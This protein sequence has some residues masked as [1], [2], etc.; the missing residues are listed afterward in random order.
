MKSIFFGAVS[1]VAMSLTTNARV[2][3]EPPGTLAAAILTWDGEYGT[4]LAGKPTNPRS[5]AIY[6]V[7]ENGG[8]HRPLVS[9]GGVTTYPRYSPAGDWLY[10]QS[11]SG[12]A[13]YQVYRCRANGSEVTSISAL[14]KLGDEWNHAFGN[15]LSGDGKKAVYSVTGG[16]PT[17]RVITCNADGSGRNGLGLIWDI[18]TWRRWT[19]PGKTWRSPVRH[20][21]TG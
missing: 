20:K 17:P 4:D 18:S 6:E 5:G 8:D 11:N 21:A 2:F 3:A 1:L 19:K 9:L 15:S 16:Q 14:H 12:G 7:S 13:T 10:F